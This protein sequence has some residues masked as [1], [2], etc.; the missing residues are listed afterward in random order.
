M[1]RPEQAIQRT[2]VQGLR[3][4]LP[5]GWLVAAVANKPRS[6]IAG[7]IEKSMGTLK[8]FPD[9]LVI[10]PGRTF[11]IEVKAEKG[12]LSPDQSHVRDRLLDLQQ[13]H[14]VV[15]SWEDVCQLARDWEW[16]WR[17]AA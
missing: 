17:A 10:G 14:A 11:Y 13:P 8:G 4:A 1:K 3:A 9:L 7:A 5:H 16:P 12:R 6:R 15:R 2:I